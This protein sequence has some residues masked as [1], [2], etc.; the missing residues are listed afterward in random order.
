MGFA[1]SPITRV[2]V[3][4]GLAAAPLQAAVAAPLDPARGGVSYG[5][6]VPEGATTMAPLAHV[7][8]C[9]ERPA[10]CEA[11]TAAASLDDDALPI[12]DRVNREVNRRIRPLAKRSTIGRWEVAPA[13]GDCND[14]AVTK[15]HALI[16][17]GLPA[18]ALRLAVARTSWGEG[19]LVLVA[20]TSA[21]DYVLDNLSNRLRPWDAT[22]HAY[23]KI[24][25]SSDPA[26]WVSVERRAPA[27]TF[28]F[29]LRL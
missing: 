26:G 11:G 16:A 21:G 2:L 22:G 23:S 3:A 5:S 9:M 19:H 15:R 4:A 10:D 27:V 20:K 25:S 12:L 13:R 7:R 17:R 24:Q 18:G 1:M 28:A 6:F 14:F 29:A 8:F